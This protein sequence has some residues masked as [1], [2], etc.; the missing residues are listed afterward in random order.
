MA[1]K[2]IKFTLFAELQGK[3]AEEFAFLGKAVRDDET[4]FFMNWIIVEAVDHTDPEKGLRGIATDGRRIHIVEPINPSAVEVYELVPGH[5]KVIKTT[6]KVTQVIRVSDDTEEQ[7]GQ[8][9]NWERVVPKEE[10]KKIIDFHGISFKED[11]ISSLLFRDSVNF[12]RAFPEPVGFNPKYLSDLPLGRLWKCYYY[13]QN[14]GVK[15]TTDNL[16]AVIM[17]MTME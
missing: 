6:R 8:F 4:R 7:C 16:L 1:E 3:L 11:K 9:P 15:F 10:P 14:K 5:Y 12:F 17:P 13:E 2:M